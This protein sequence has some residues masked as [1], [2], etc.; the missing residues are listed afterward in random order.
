MTNR[1]EQ[2]T[3]ET[4]K[5]FKK[6]NIVLPGDYSEEFIHNALK[7][8]YDLK[9]KEIFEGDLKQELEKLDKIFEQTSEG[10]NVLSSSTSQAV[11]AIEKKR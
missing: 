3:Y 7:M 8:G 5:R 4:M 11:E 6:N 9:D 1:L 2:V 10:L